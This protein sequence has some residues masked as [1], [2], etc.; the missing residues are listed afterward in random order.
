VQASFEELPRDPFML[1]GAF[2]D[3]KALFQLMRGAMLASAAFVLIRDEGLGQGTV[4][5]ANNSSTAVSNSLTQQRVPAGTTF[6][7]SL[8]CHPDAANAPTTLDFDLRG[9]VLAP[10]TS[11]RPAAGLYAGGARTTPSFIAPSGDGWFQVRVWESAFGSTYEQARLAPPTDRFGLFGVSEPIR[12]RTGSPFTNISPG[13][14]TAFGLRPIIVTNLIPIIPPGAG[15][16]TFVVTNTLNSGAGSLHQALGAALGNA[17]PDTIVFSNVTGRITLPPVPPTLRDVTVIGPGAR[18]LTVVWPRFLVEPGAASTLSRLRIEATPDTKTNVNGGIIWNGGTLTIRDCELVGGNVVQGSGG[19]I[20]NEGN[21]TMV[22]STIVSNSYGSGIVIQS[23]T[24][25]FANCT[26][27]DN[28]YFSLSMLSGS[29]SLTH[30]TIAKPIALGTGLERSAGLLAVENSIIA[31]RLYGITQLSLDNLVTNFASAGLGPLQDNGGPT[32]THALLPTSP[33]IDRGGSA[34]PTDQRGVRRPQGQR[35]DAGAFELEEPPILYQLTTAA[36]SHGSVAL[37]PALYLY[38]ANSVVEVRAI[39]EEDYLLDHWSGDATG[40]ANPLMVVLDRHKSITAAFRYAPH[41][42]IHPPGFTNIVVNTNPWGPGSLR[43]AVRNLNASGGG[44]ILFSNVSGT[45]MLSTGLPPITANTVIRGPGADRLTVGRA[46]T[47]TNNLF[48]FMPGTT[49]EISRLAFEY[50]SAAIGVFNGAVLRLD[51]VRM[52]GNSPALNN[53]GTLFVSRSVLRTN[54]PAIFSDGYLTLFNSSFEGNRQWGQNGRWEPGILGSYVG[55]APTSASG[56]ALSVSGT[57]S[58]VNCTFSG[59]CVEGG[60]GAFAPGIEYPG[61]NGGNALGGAIY[62]DGGS[63]MITNATFSAN[64]ARGGQNGSATFCY[65]VGPPGD[66]AGGAVYVANATVFLQNVTMVSNVTF[67][68]GIAY[69][70]LGT[71]PFV[72]C[73]P[74]EC[75][76]G[77]AAVH[78]KSGV[79]GLAN[80]LVAYNTANG[81]N[82]VAALGGGYT[83]YVSAGFNLHVDPSFLTNWLSSDKLQQDPRIGP[84]EDN[85]GP[86]RTHALLAGS[87]AIDA[88]TSGGLAFDQRGQ[89]RPLDHPGV[90]NAPGSDGT[91]IGAFEVD[92]VLRLTGI[93]RA[94]NDVRVSFTT[95][96]DKTYGLQTKS[97]VTSPWMPL[98]NVIP[99]SGG[100]VTF[101]NQGGGTLSQRFYRAVQNQP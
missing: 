31:G 44:M 29:V 35:S 38:P 18:L 15:G 55:F 27:S 101:T 83:N 57:S 32:L 21:L 36:G 61:M 62:F 81:S 86:T 72:Q 17:G 10:P 76:A 8:H 92:P 68:S 79:V 98:P 7:V 12:V 70:T 64:L 77:G 87:P 71:P 16:L 33:A 39:A 46:G 34:L 82:A 60:V 74:F 73:F 48:N 52:H 85:G 9:A 84:L 2:V 96:S 43:Q 75:C 26:F 28:Y 41:T 25:S 56:G 54:Y 93:A 100:I 53:H 59:N 20:Y 80:A 88:G 23:G 50:C 78:V 91:D 99:G 3:M 37:D 90:P 97:S 19:A 5:F 95:V 11:I 58:I 13:A 45:I 66:S 67:R 30:C 1:G 89:P 24:A 65:R 47:I 49:G 40:N 42:V 6:L 22:G 69:S 51:E 63:L 4:N 94:S 14:L